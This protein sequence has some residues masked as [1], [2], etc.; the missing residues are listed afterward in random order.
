MRGGDERAAPR[1]PGEDDVARLVADEERAL[2]GASRGGVIE[3]DDADAVREVVDDP[4]LAV[5]AGGDGDRLEADRD[6][7]G[8]D[9]LALLDAKDL[10]P[11]VGRV[12]GEQEL[13][14]GRD[15]ERSHLS[16]LEGRELRGGGLC[17]EL[18]CRALHL[19]LRRIAGEI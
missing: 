18:L 3:L 16:A 17:R 6:R 11:V 9:E 1:G 13:L 14:V 4:D 8:A 5:R 7:G 19:A 12:D 2:D 10:E 15:R